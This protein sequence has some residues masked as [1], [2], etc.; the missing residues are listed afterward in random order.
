MLSF[1][2]GE[3]LPEGTIK[4]DEEPAKW[5]TVNGNRIPLNESGE[6]IGGNPKALGGAKSSEYK[7]KKGI[8]GYEN[9]VHTGKEKKKPDY[10]RAITEQKNKK[11]SHVDPATGAEVTW[12]TGRESFEP[13]KASSSKANRKGPKKRSEYLWGWDDNKSWDQ[14]NS[15]EKIG[16]IYTMIDHYGYSKKNGGRVPKETVRNFIEW[17]DKDGIDRVENEIEKLARKGEISNGKK[18]G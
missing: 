13:Y 2:N 3:L 12:N 16:S 17:A 10:T 11:K 9:F 6:A 4:L 5:I 18:P 15:H 14:L 8:E 1:R 7:P